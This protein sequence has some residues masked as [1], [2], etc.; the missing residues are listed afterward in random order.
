MFWQRAFIVARLIC[1]SQVAI[2][3][4]GKKWQNSIHLPLQ[5]TRYCPHL[6]L[7]YSEKEC[8]VQHAIIFLFKWKDMLFIKHAHFSTPKGQN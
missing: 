5:F 8:H 2:F 1:S 4:I 6:T 3:V 7:T